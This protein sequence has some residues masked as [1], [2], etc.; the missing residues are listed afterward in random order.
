MKQQLAPES[1]VDYGA[2]CVKKG[3]T[4]MSE[5]REELRAKQWLR[6]EGHIDIL[7]LS[8]D[9]RDPPDF[10]VEGR[11]GVEVRRLNRMTGDTNR[12]LE[13][14]E[15]PLEGDIKAGLRAAG[16]PP[17]GYKV[18]VDCDLLRADLPAREVIICEVKH[19]TDQYIEIIREAFQVGH[20][21]PCSPFKLDCGM[22]IEFVPGEVAAAGSFEL[23]AVEAATSSRLVI[24][25]SIDNINR[26][27]EVKTDKI[28]NRVHRYPQ[29]WLVLVDHNI[30]TPG[31][32]ETDEWQ[33]IRD[34]LVDTGPWARIVVISWMDCL[35]HVDLILDG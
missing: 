2:W 16:E 4:A 35:M 13:S 20:R 27:I 28:K 9:N 8:E 1:A 10:V 6:N 33:T 24:P 32:W 25:D 26:C 23:N 18:F 5:N 19:A 30:H 14:V 29:W 21:P 3:N 22:S 11:I 15:K 7:D 17:G 31:S 34:N 12:G